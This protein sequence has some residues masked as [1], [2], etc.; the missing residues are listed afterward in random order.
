MSLTWWSDRS[1][2]ER[3]LLGGLGGLLLLFAL[4]F[5]VYAPLRS[6]SDDAYANYRSA[7]ALLDEV[8]AGAR[9]AETLKA[10]RSRGPGAGSL[11]SIASSSAAS[12]GVAITR[13]QPEPGEGLNV[14]LEDVDAKALYGWIVALDETHG[15]GVARAS[16]RANDR[17]DTVWAQL[18]LVGGD[19]P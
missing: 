3:A 11:R 12:A 18:L 8:E 2:R 15:V 17:R 10:R 14:W 5:L 4:Y 19:A 1:E 16:I 9:E 6:F 7:A 13:I